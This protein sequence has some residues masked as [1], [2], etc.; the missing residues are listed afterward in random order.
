MVSSA[1][2][3]V[4]AYLLVS[5]IALA[6]RYNTPIMQRILP[7]ISSVGRRSLAQRTAAAVRLRHTITQN[8]NFYTQPTTYTSHHTLRM[9]MMSTNAPQQSDDD[10]NS[11]EDDDDS[12]EYVEPSELNPSGKC[13][14]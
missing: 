13:V 6:Y 3:R 7:L 9:S 1:K 8:N 12:A 14:L 10:N 5:I 11:S 2:G 4:A